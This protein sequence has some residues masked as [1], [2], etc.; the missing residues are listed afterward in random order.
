VA[1]VIDRDDLI[2]AYSGGVPAGFVPP[3]LW[4]WAWPEDRVRAKW[5]KPDSEAAKK[6]LAE[7]GHGA[8]F[9]TTIATAGLYRP[10]AEVL[11]RQLAG[12]GIEATVEEEPGSAFTAVLQRARF[13]IGYGAY[14]GSAF[15]NFWVGDFL[16]SDSGFNFL[17]IN[18][19]K[20]DSLVAA[21]GKELDKAKRQQQLNELQN[22]LHDTVPY[23]PAFSHLYHHFFSCRLKNARQTLT[24]YNNPTA[25]EAWLDPTGC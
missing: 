13:D 2:A 4:D 5:G 17:G 10:G 9:R 19:P 3:Y 24:T 15:P 23:I 12:I 16:R 25:L 20:V 22:H 18:D 6:L 21:H 1:L 7:A 8:G 11:Q 14:P